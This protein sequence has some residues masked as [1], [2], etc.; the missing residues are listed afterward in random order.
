MVHFNRRHVVAFAIA[1]TTIWARDGMA[2]TVPEPVQIVRRFYQPYLKDDSAGGKS[3]LDV[4][5]PHATPE[6]RRLIAK[7]ETCARKQQGIC[8]IEADVLIDGQDWKLS[9]FQVTALNVSEDRIT[10]RAAFR[11]TGRPTIVEFPFVKSGDR[12]LITDVHMKTSG[13]TLINLLKAAN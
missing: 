10:V 9:A 13:E 3:A 7:E 11:N 6:L 5:K 8:N 12:W 2:Q 1:T 4:I